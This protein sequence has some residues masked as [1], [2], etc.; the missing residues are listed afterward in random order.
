MEGEK[1]TETEIKLNQTLIITCI[2]VEIHNS[3]F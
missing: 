2:V 1:K 3:S